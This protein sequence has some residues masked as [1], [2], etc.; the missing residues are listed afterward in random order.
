MLDLDEGST[1]RL[2]RKAKADPALCDLWGIDPETLTA[3]PVPDKRLEGLGLISPP[4]TGPAI[5]VYDIENTPGLAWVWGAYDQNVIAMERDWHLLSFAY[6]WLNTDEVGFVSMYQD[7]EFYADTTN[8]KFVAE[9]LAALFDRADVVVAHNGDK[10]DRRKAN[11]RFLFWGIDPPSPYQTI[12][13]LKIAKREF[14]NYSNSLQELG[15]IHEL[16][17]KVQN[18]GFKLWRD[19]MRGDTAAWQMMEDYNR[20]D[21][22]LLESLY[23]KLLPWIGLPGKP[24]GINYGFWNKGTMV[25]PN[26]GHDHLTEAG[27]HRTLV[28][29]FEVYRCER[30]RSLSRFRTRIPQTKDTAV[31]LV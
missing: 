27:V 18:S 23:I 2:I 17:A 3:E 20:Q 5:L 8:D 7:P 12:D 24:S 19:C 14:N 1:R 11:A 6:K 28:S 30:C 13:T 9:R 25:C 21:V 31:K 4:E 26:C 22:V 16:G 15:R 10:F 29:E